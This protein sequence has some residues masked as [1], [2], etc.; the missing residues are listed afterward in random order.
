M[1][2][3]LMF[4]AMALSGGA[5]AGDTAAANPPRSITIQS[6]NP[7]PDDGRISVFLAGSI[8]MGGSVDW[9]AQVARELADEGV[10]LL[11]PRRDDWNPAWKPSAEEPEFRRQVEWELAALQRADVIAMYFAPGS[12]SP[13]TLLEL[14]L[15]AGSGKLLLACPDGFWRKGNV[16][17]T[18][19]RYHVPR[20]DSLPAL[21]AAVRERVER[22]RR[23][24]AGG[25]A[26]TGR[27]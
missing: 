4:S 12:Q 18:A 10:V 24:R 22:L 27:G 19:D 5:V 16:D 3:L 14:G 21:V 13:V 15:H 7:L 2:A 17:I 25:A 6:P 11:N 23:A 1:K 20:F 9:Q 26:G 8:D